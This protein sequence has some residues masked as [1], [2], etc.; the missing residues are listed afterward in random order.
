MPIT[1]VSGE[2]INIPVQNM[3]KKNSPAVFRLLE[4]LGHGQQTRQNKK[5][6]RR[7]FIVDLFETSYDRSINVRRNTKTDR[8]TRT[9][10]VPPSLL[11]GAYRSVTIAMEPYVPP[12]CAL[13]FHMHCCKTWWVKI[14]S[15]PANEVTQRKCGW[16]RVSLGLLAELDATAPTLLSEAGIHMEKGKRNANQ[17]W[18][19]GSETEKAEET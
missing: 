9:T 8:R 5:L 14:S 7:L 16:V 13:P 15:I 12:R 11:P 19:K 6:P 2:R 10:P 18:Q 1:N 17:K 3:T 4:N